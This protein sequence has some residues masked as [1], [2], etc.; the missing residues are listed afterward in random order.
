MRNNPM[1]RDEISLQGGF[2]REGFFHGLAVALA[3]LA[4]VLRTVVPAG[5]MPSMADGQVRLVLCSDM[6]G[7]TAGQVFDAFS[8][9]GHETSDDPD[10][11]KAHLSHQP[12][13]FHGLGAP[14]LG[15]MAASVGPCPAGVFAT[16]GGVRPRQN[17]VAFDRYRHP[18]LRGPPVF[19]IEA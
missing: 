5:F 6:V 12:C 10:S 7:P 11:A 8:T 18:P 13:A 15:G 14:L 3:L 1:A 4:L 9:S 17:M 19:M 16:L 2:A